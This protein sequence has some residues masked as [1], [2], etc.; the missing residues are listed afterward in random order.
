[1]A[2]HA[3]RGGDPSDYPTRGYAWYMVVLLTVA[4]IFSFIDRWA[5]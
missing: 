3:A 2:I 4:Y 1:M 5:R